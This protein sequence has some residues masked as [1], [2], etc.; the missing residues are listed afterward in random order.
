MSV[1][2]EIGDGAETEDVH[3]NPMQ[4]PHPPHQNSLLELME[5]DVVNWS[6][7]ID[8][9][10][11]YPHEAAFSSRGKGY[12]V[13]NKALWKRAP[14]SVIQAIVNAHPQAAF[15]RSTKGVTPLHIAVVFGTSEIIRFIYEANPE[16]ASQQ[17]TN[18]TIP[19]HGAKD[20]DTTLMLIQGFPR[21]VC[22][23]GY[24]RNLPLHAAAYSP[25]ASP[26][27]VKL[28]I[29]AGK[30]YHLGGKNG[31]GGVLVKNEEGDTS[32]SLVC[33]FIEERFGWDQLNFAGHNQWKKLIS[34]ARAAYMALK[35]DHPC[36][37][38]ISP[39][40]IHQEKNPQLQE[41]RMLHLLVALR[42]PA[43]VIW[44]ALQMYPHQSKEQDQHGQYPLTIASKNVLTDSS[45]IKMLLHEFAG[46]AAIP[47]AVSGRLPLVLSIAAGREYDD[48]LREILH[49]APSAIE[50]R[51]P[52]TG[53][54]PFMIAA[55]GE[56]CSINTVFSLLLEAPCLVDATSRMDE[57]I[58][59]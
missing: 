26:E 44:H 56:T 48:G 1:E 22:V 42:C 5:A 7:V 24:N 52:E 31:N 6:D 8:R 41:L 13:L 51:D 36:K 37:K 34:I 58:I 11:M 18:G 4:Q 10:Q 12:R 33:K 32:L 49:A 45:V 16:A 28:L 40:Q 47:C 57:S 54:Y 19:L 20:K 55:L 53:L 27:V 59:K 38:S 35:G 25:T 3:Q 14:L 9:L 2:L 29:G 15:G 30:R 23:R 43:V 21:G 17:T 46:A 50:A 39:C